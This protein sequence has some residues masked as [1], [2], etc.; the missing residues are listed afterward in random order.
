M[1]LHRSR[2]SSLKYEQHRSITVNH[3]I[4]NRQEHR[5][6]TNERNG[7]KNIVGGFFYLNRGKER[8]GGEGEDTLFF[9]A[10]NVV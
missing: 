8:G 9:L 5:E 2:A 1:F 6:G 7:G 3:L 4:H 10:R